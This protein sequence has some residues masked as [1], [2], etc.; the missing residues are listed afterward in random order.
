[1]DDAKTLPA[2]VG[3]LTVAAER[4]R[5]AKRM[6]VSQRVQVRLTAQSRDTAVTELL[7]RRDLLIERVPVD[8]EVQV[9]PESRQDGDVLIIPVLAER[10][11]KR[12]FVTEE[13]HIRQRNT[14][15]PFTQTVAL[16]EER[17]EVSTEEYPMDTANETDLAPAGHDVH[18]Y[19]PNIHDNQIVAVYDTLAQAEAAQATLLGAGIEPGAMELIDGNRTGMGAE[20]KDTGLW[21]A[22]K[23]LFAPDE[24]A[25]AFQHAIGRGHA[26]L[27]VHPA[28][29]ANREQ[30]IT[31]LEST[32]PIDFDAKLEEW[33]QSGYDYS[34]AG[35]DSVRTETPTGAATG[36]SD[37]A[38]GAVMAAGAG[39]AMMTGAM[40]VVA[41]SNKMVGVTGTSAPAMST[42]ATPAPAMPAPAIPVASAP[43]VTPPATASAATSAMGAA[44]ETGTI[45][46]MEE[47]LRVGKREVAAG[48]VRVRSYVVERPVEEQ[49]R[50]HEERINVRRT[51]VD[52]AVTD[53][54]AAVFQERTIEARA[55]SEQAVIAKEVRIVEEIDVEKQGTDRTETVRDTVRQTKVELEDTT[56]VSHE[57]AT[58]G[59]TTSGANSPRPE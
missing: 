35:Q 16:R 13:I 42:P 23:S 24:E 39:G 17:A 29:T 15:E 1:M 51:P 12:L 30:I 32:G 18:L 37:T 45:K 38:M 57:T 47:R 46:V 3:R 52:R 54:D 2:L 5:V 14:H 22:V 7:A 49:V 25:L 36:T 11:V 20:Q 31:L 44:A 19:D 55:M 41:D 4:L 43:V 40:P 9:A 50:L 56:K 28:L 33:R 59:A 6:V 58:P 21:G 27:L 8:R 48:T 34:K 53:A 26:M 10:M